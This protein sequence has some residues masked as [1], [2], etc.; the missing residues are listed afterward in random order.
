MHIQEIYI[1]G[2][3]IIIRERQK[4]KPQK[5]IKRAPKSKPT[6]E[7]VWLYNLK[8]AIF[9]LTLILNNNF[10]P[11]DHHIQL[12]H[13][14]NPK[15]REEAK[16]A[17]KKFTRK[18]SALC[19]K[20]GIE[21][22][23]VAV[24]EKSKKGRYHHHIICSNV[25]T[26]LIQEAWQEGK[27]FHNPLWDDYNYS[28][29]AEYLVKEAASLFE[30]EGVISKKRYT[31]SRNIEVP[32]CEEKEITRRTIE[33]EPKALKGYQIDQDTLQVYENELTGSICREYIMVSLEDEPKKRRKTKSQMTTGEY[34]NYSKAL[35]EAYS[36]VQEK[37]ESLIY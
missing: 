28:R 19:K 21:L 27:V 12:T 16:S 29:L 11:G 7:K 20:E 4:R 6:A 8:Q 30:E 35:R 2:K 18:L 24:T 34:I 31:T 15:T 22:K 32:M 36:E 13:K 17:R 10:A 25:P 3:T 26:R 37:I 23:W 1:A 14:E 5:G 33:A 9:K